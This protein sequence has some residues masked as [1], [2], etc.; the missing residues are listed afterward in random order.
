MPVERL[1]GFHRTYTYLQLSMIQVK[2]NSAEFKKIREILLELADKPERRKSVKLF[3]IRAYE[4]LDKRILI[5]SAI[6]YD[7]NYETIVDYIS[8]N[9][10]KKLFRKEKE[11]V[12]YFKSSA[13]S[14]W[15]EFP[16]LFTGKL[17][18]SIPRLKIVR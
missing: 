9:K 13:K 4:G 11:D 10:S 1:L 15:I 7:I 16:F 8:L 17:N 5:K 14:K 2:R 6:I 3:A 12:Y 18:R